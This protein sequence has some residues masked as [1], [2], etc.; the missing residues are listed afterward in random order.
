[1]AGRTSQAGRR[2][3]AQKARA[4]VSRTRRAASSSAS[5]DGRNPF[6][7]VTALWMGLAHALGWVVR[8][9]GRQAATAKELDREHQRDGGGLLLI[10]VAIVLAVAVWFR[11]AGPI[12]SWLATGTHLAVGA[13]AMALPL[14][15]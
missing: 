6:R 13:V 14:L 9:I 2:S 11:G 3:S 5:T 8:A 1:M 10:G 7:V 12:G 4:E 15:L